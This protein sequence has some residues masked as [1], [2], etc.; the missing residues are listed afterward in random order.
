MKVPARAPVSVPT[1]TNS[2]GQV[3]LAG[4]AVNVLK[5]FL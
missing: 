3:V 2:E 5:H 4:P 1:S